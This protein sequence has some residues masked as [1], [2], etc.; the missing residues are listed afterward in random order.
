MSRLAKTLLGG[1]HHVEVLGEEDDLAGAARQL[2]GVVGGQLCLGL[3]D[4][5][6][7]R[8]D[9]VPGALV[10]A[11]GD[12]ALG[13]AAYQG[14][15]D[16]LGDRAGT[17]VLQRRLV[18]TDQAL[19]ELALGVA[20]RAADGALELDRQ[21]G[22]PAGRDVGGHVDL[23]PADDAEVDDRGP[24]GRVE[25]VVGGG[26]A[27]LLQRRH[28]VVP[29]LALL[30]PSE[31]L[32]D[33]PEV[34]DVVDQ[35][36]AGQRHQQRPRDP[37]A[38]PLGDLDDVLGP[39]RLLVLDVVRLVDHHAAEPVVADPV[40]MPVEHLVVD[41]DD[42]GEP[43]DRL[44]VAVD[45]GHR[46]AGRPPL[47]L[48]RPVGLDHVGD[49]GQQRVG[50]RDL[51][52]QQCLRRL[53]EPGL[54]GQEEGPVARR[55]GGQQTRLV[56]HEVQALRRLRRPGLRKVHAGRSARG[57]M[58]ERVEHGPDQLPADQATL[59]PWASPG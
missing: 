43:V 34:L 20:D 27:G 19:G 55:H 28:Q 18:A 31:E 45:H 5:A 51:R 10:G 39:L 30:D 3:P 23:A 24:R 6:H 17:A 29:G 22:D 7:H 12:L 46:P 58:L 14:V 41:H 57:G 36:G 48:T 52:G 53:A 40:D 56:G 11:L 32:P 1:V 54:V 26:Q 44:A 2:R 47:R 4:P 50:A 13:H 59:R 38:D 8:E 25:R 37:L 16:P 49:D 21:V 33:R 9:V 15:V 35:R 42:V